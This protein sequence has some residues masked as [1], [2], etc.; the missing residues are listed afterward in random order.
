[1]ITKVVKAGDKIDLVKS[2]TTV[3]NEEEKK[4]YRSQ[5]YDVID[6][7][8]LK[9]AM[10]Q[11]KG[12]LLLLELEAVYYLQFYTEGGLYECKGKVVDRYKTDNIYVVVVDI[13]SA[14]KK[15]QRREFYR[16][17]C[18]LDGQIHILD[19]EELMAGDI[20]RILEIHE[21][22]KAVYEKAVIVDISGGGARIATDCPVEEDSYITLKFRVNF[23]NHF[24]DYELLAHV[25]TRRKMENRK[26]DY[27]LRVEFEQIENNVRESLIKYIFEEERKKRKSEKS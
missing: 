5:V 21:R 8:Q 24:Q 26:K 2:G 14:M 15:I 18:L 1:M 7:E 4:V 25:V 11:E 3:N 12:R 13:V 19:E 16:L 17:N 10:P 6:E 20:M 23:K 9:I 27:E 22:K